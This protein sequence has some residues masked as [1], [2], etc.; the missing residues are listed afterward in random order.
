MA[1][2]KKSLP[3]GRIFLRL[4]YKEKYK[5]KEI[6]RKVSYLVKQ[7]KLRHAGKRHVDQHF[8]KIKLSR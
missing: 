7:V 3:T 5:E 1:I 6:R 8:P 4:K 2:K